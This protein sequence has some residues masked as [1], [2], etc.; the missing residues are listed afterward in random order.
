MGG[1]AAVVTLGWWFLSGRAPKAS[2]EPIKITPFTSD[3]GWKAWPRISPDGEKVAYSWTG[4]AEDNLDIYVK[5]LGFGTR[6]FRLI[7]VSI[8]PPCRHIY[9]DSIPKDM[10]ARGLTGALVCTLLR[11]SR[12]P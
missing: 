5:A 7:A 10:C 11:S 6:P 9:G 1:L 4:P 8:S 12:R 2:T 3:G